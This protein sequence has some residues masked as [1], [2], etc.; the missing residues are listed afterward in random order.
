LITLVLLL[1]GALSLVGGYLGTHWYRS[2]NSHVPE[3]VKQSLPA[4]RKHLSEEH[5]HLGRVSNEFSETVPKG[6][7]IS[8]SPSSGTRLEQG[9]SVDVTVSLGKYRLIVP[10]VTN[11]PV[12]KAEALLQTRGFQ[13]DA[14]LSYRASMTVDNGDVL[15]T[16]P[17]A[18]SRIR[19]LATVSFVVS[20]GPPILDIPTVPQGTA[21]TS[22]RRTLTDAKFTVVRTEE[23]SDEVPSGAVI[24]VSP[25]G[26][27]PE[28]SK[29]TVTVSKGPEFVSMPVIATLSSFDDAKAE[30]EQLGLRVDRR[31]VYGGGERNLVIGQDPE[32][33]QSVR[34]GS[35]V[36]L[37]VI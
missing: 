32:A 22:A 26:Q 29:V 12:D 1:I 21:F 28:G 35:T 2:W 36:I 4:A 25:T 23:F 10:D 17:G 27:A 19:P 3:L 37:D 31:V 13:F 5:Y 9:K 8:T 15:A 16:K 7:I 11:M 33:G 34:V 6:S 18:G 20:S 30:L 14:N 24:S